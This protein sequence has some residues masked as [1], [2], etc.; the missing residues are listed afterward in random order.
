MGRMK[1][2]KFAKES[3]KEANE[4]PQSKLCSL[5]FLTSVGA[6]MCTVYFGVGFYLVFW[7]GLLKDCI[8]VRGFI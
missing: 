4:I 6:V 7:P 3:E 5:T 1:F 8:L 2:V